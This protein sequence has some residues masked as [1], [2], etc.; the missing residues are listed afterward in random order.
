MR[1]V[2]TMIVFINFFD[3]G[4]SK[5]AGG[6]IQYAQFSTQK[7]NAFIRLNLDKSGVK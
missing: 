3:I 7:K 5:P 2:I 4:I 1:M 6:G